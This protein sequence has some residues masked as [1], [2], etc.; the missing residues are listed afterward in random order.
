MSEVWV[1]KLIARSWASAFSRATAP[2]RAS[3]TR[4]CWS[5]ARNSRPRASGHDQGAAHGAEPHRGARGSRA[6]ASAARRSGAS[7]AGSVLGRAATDGLSV[8]AAR[9]RGLRPAG[10]ARPDRLD[11]VARARLDDQPSP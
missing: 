10:A 11:A 5:S 7:S 1:K 8:A 6:A 4:S 9:G 3:A 2:C